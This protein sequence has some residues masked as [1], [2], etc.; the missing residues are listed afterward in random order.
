MV[1]G[2]TNTTTG[3]SLQV[4][5]IPVSVTSATLCSSLQNGDYVEAKGLLSNGTLA[6]Y[7]IEFKTTDSERNLGNYADDE[8]DNDHDDLKYRR[9]A[10]GTSSNDSS[11][12]VNTGTYELYGTLSNCTTSTC[13]FTSNGVVMSIDISTAVWEHGI[14]VT[15]GF[16]EA[17][18]YMLSNNVFKAIK[19]ESKNRT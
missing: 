19:I 12:F 5:G 17:K 13:S 16:V 1:S 7:R 2:L 11:S 3:C 8:N 6:A 15:S 18:G 10:S 4:Q 14:V 9:I